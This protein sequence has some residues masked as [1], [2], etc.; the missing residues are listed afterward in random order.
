MRI[1]G[2]LLCLLATACTP[3]NVG[4]G[5]DDDDATEEVCNG[6][7]G[8]TQFRF[9]ID[10]FV[11]LPYK[12]GTSNPWD[13]DGDIPDWLIEATGLIADALKDPRIKAAEE[14]LELID[15]YAQELLEGTIPPDPILEVVVADSEYEYSA[16]PVDT[17]D[18]TYEPWFG[19]YYDL[20]LLPG[21]TLWLDLID[22]DLIAD[23]Y[24]GSEL[25]TE[26]D[27]KDF[28]G[29]GPTVFTGYPEESIYLFQV[30]VEA[31]D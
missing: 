26:Q 2:L 21:E 29:C 16:G 14:V 6:D 24:I 15:T 8:A 12:I 25:F 22:E 7:Q 17:D 27:L 18:N 9:H 13:W 30:E 10:G 5:S 3:A 4:P 20:E 31:L 23:D 28:A 11:I 1:S 19:V